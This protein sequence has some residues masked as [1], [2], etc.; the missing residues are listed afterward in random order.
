MEAAK[1]C[2]EVATVDLSRDN[3]IAGI[4]NW[5]YLGLNETQCLPD[6]V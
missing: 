1:S 5:E 6:S 3:E 4:M 2:D